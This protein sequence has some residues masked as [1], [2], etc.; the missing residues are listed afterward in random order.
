M[1]ASAN[2]GKEKPQEA[3]HDRHRAPFKMPAS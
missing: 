3:P 1:T 2:R